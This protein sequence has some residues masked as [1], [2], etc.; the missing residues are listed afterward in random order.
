MS[1][2]RTPGFIY[3]RALGLNL[4]ASWSPLPYALVIGRVVKVGR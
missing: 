3:V 4:A 2:I 1:V